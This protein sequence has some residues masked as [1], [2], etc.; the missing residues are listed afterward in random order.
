[1]MTRRNHVTMRESDDNIYHKK[2]LITWIS[3]ADEVKSFS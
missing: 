2:M 3:F 1:M